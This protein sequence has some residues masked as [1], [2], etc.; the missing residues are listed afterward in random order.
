M[1]SIQEENDEEAWKNRTINWIDEDNELSLLIANI[2]GELEMDIWIN[3]K[4]NL[5]IVRATVDLNL[6]NSSRRS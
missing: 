4:T 2:N 1:T 6:I 3:T 5:G